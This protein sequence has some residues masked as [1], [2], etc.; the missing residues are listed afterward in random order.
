[1]TSAAIATIIL[2]VVMVL[3]VTEALPLPVTALAGAL[4]M[5]T[6]GVISYKQ[7]F[8]G[9]AN[10][11]LMMVVGMLIIGRALFESGLVWIVGKRV[12]ALTCLGSRTAVGVLGA[13]VSLLSGFMSNTSVVAASLPLAD[14]LDH[15]TGGR[16]SKRALA[17]P[18]GVAAVLGG[19]LTLVGS[20]P[21]LVAQGILEDAGL[22]TLGFF[23][24]LPG[25]AILLA[26]G[27]A[28]YL[29]V[30]SKWLDRATAGRETAAAPA[31]TPGEDDPARG[32]TRQMAICG[33]VFVLCVAG[34][35][36]GLWTVGT[37]SMVG[38][39][40]LVVTKCISLDS[41]RQHVCWTTVV[42]LGGSLGLSAGLDQSGAGQAIADSI[43]ALCG[44][45]DSQPLLIFGAVVF[46]AAALSNCMSNTAV[47]AML[48]PTSIHLAQ[49]LNFN[50]LTMIIGLVF[51]AS[52][53]FATPIGTPPMTLT[54]GAGYRF[55][56]YLR[57]GSPLC[58]LLTALTVVIVPLIYSAA[59]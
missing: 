27:L 50:V 55:R 54:L 33:T 21:Q 49:A 31:P 23:T 34:F 11:T 16:T 38:A 10:D 56:E 8:A 7:A 15:H 48:A 41:I 51:G 43:V 13:A 46:I 22:P 28:Y 3:F 6:T 59:P 25:G 29:L 9:F 4:A 18:I 53:C 32:S 39:L 52:V 26:T 12:A 5:S 30:G 47:V 45:D 44:G 19:N 42:I 17:M 40:V 35:V 20:T 24:L 14:S 1:M 36:A 37:V 2:I 58:V 57:I